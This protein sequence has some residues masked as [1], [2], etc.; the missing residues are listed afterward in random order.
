MPRLMNVPIEGWGD[1]V[2]II[3]SYADTPLIG[4]EHS[5][6]FVFLGGPIAGT[7]SARRPGDATAFHFQG[8]RQV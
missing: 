5:R 7:N 8:R 1:S 3:T 6:S 2:L 4:F